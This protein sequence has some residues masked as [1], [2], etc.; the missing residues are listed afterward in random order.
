[1]KRK[2]QANTVPEP[3]LTDND[4]N[5]RFVAAKSIILNNPSDMAEAVGVL[6]ELPNDAS[7]LGVRVRQSLARFQV[8]VEENFDRLFKM[9]DE[10]RHGFVKGKLQKA[11]SSIPTPEANKAMLD[12]SAEVQKTHC[13]LTLKEFA[14][15]PPYKNRT[16][17]AAIVLVQ[18]G[19]LGL[20]AIMDGV[21]SYDKEVRLFSI[22]CVSELLLTHY[23]EWME[24][25]AGILDHWDISIK[26]YVPR[27]LWRSQAL[28]ALPKL[29]Q[30]LSDVDFGFA[31]L[32]AKAI[33]IIDP[34]KREDSLRFVECLDIDKR[35]KSH[36]L[37]ELRGEKPYLGL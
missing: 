22:M 11:V 17:D 1:M 28:F 19:D 5:R 31:A 14:S 20:D 37:A 29:E 23:Q 8:E 16:S 26:C 7:L 15:F 2:E 34:S 18:F 3:W 32:C 30:C 33:A 36:L 24:E 25:I 35:F 13:D 10:D 21:Y 6:E 9:T 12:Q 27:M 4:P